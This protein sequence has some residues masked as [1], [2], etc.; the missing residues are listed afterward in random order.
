MP[1]RR[2]WRVLA[3]VLREH[4][5]GRFP[6]ALYHLITSARYSVLTPAQTAL[7]PVFRESLILTHSSFFFLELVVKRSL[8]NHVP[9]SRCNP[10]PHLARLPARAEDPRHPNRL[11]CLGE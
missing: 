7:S 4:P 8:I 10:D 1:V 11:R 5:A 2:G 6:Q 9:L 3:Y